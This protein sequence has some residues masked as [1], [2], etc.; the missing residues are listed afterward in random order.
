[1][2]TKRKRKKGKNSKLWI[3]GKLC[4]NVE[5]DLDIVSNFTH[6]TNNYIINLTA[7]QIVLESIFCS[8]YSVFLLWQ[9]II[10]IFV[11]QRSTWFIW[12]RFWN[13]NLEAIWNESTRKSLSNACGT[14]SVF[15]RRDRHCMITETSIWRHRNAMKGNSCLTIKRMC[16]EKSTS[17]LTI[18]NRCFVTKGTRYLTL[19]NMF[20]EQMLQSCDFKTDMTKNMDSCRTLKW[21]FRK[22]LPFPHYIN[23]K[24][25][26]MNYIIIR[27]EQ[28]IPDSSV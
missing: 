20:P 13:Y 8:W 3:S 2:I 17:S 4:S 28:V 15:R 10:V 27:D 7:F 11:G 26:K 5:S 14:C 9:N 22:K 6:S 23:D 16:S 18:K 24:S 12:F 25:R 1:M 19:G 21:L